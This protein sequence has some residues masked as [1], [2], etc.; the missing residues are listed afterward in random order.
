MGGSDTEADAIGDA[1][2]EQVRK[3]MIFAQ[4]RMERDRK[5]WANRSIKEIINNPNSSAT[6]REEAQES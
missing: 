6:L 4:F 1:L 5:R 3:L 2:K